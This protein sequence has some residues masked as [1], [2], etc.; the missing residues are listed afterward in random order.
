MTVLAVLGVLGFLVSLFTLTAR[1]PKPAAVRTV[2][3][4]VSLTCLG[5][6]VLTWKGDAIGWLALAIGLGM[7]I[8]GVTQVRAIRSSRVR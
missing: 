5:L 4:G 7:L 8:W 2:S 1:R 6:L 3:L